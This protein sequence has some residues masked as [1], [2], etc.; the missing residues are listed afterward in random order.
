MRGAPVWLASL[1]RR[2]P[3]TGGRLATPLWSPELMDTSIELL[4]R[5]LDGA[6]MPERERIF[7]MQVTVCI[8][9]ALNDAELQQLPDYFWQDDAT[10]LAGGP[11]EIL[12]ESEPGL[13]S[14]RPCDNPTRIPLDARQPLLWFPGDCGDCAPCRA[15]AKLSSDGVAPA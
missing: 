9:R 2:S 8:H 1:S 5:V 13:A 14:T 15:R 7:R 10:D 4:H 12:F 6:G 11:V 3:L